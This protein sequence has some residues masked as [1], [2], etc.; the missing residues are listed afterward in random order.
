MVNSSG[1]HGGP[2][3]GVCPPLNPP[4]TLA[5]ICQR[6]CL[7]RRLYTFSPTH[8][9]SYPKF[10]NPRTNYENKGQSRNRVQLKGV[11]KSRKPDLPKHNSCSC[12]RNRNFKSLFWFQLNR[13]RKLDFTRF[14]PEF[15]RISQKLILFKKCLSRKLYETFLYNK[16]YG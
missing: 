3:S 11:F 14:R 1:A 7:Q 9:K 12:Y 15:T 13:N 5:E 6:M 2:R 16:R 10:R 8:Q 4:L